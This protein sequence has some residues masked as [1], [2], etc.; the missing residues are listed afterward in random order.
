LLA[1]AIMSNHVHL[2]VGVNGDPDPTKVLGDFKAYAS[3]ALT[4][5]WRKPP[6]GTWWTYAGSKRKLPDERAV[7]DAINYVRRQPN[8]LIAWTPGERGCVSAPS[9]SELGARRNSGR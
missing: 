3:R 4:R 5:R 6:S 9:T 2:V 1:V 8:A 7:N